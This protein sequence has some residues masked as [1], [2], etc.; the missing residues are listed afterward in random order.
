[1]LEN[2]SHQAVSPEWQ[3]KELIRALERTNKKKEV[4]KVR[5]HGFRLLCSSPPAVPIPK[6]R[7]KVAASCFTG[8]SYMLAPLMRT[9]L[10]PAVSDKTVT[11]MSMPLFMIYAP[12]L[13]D[14]DIGGAKL[15]SPYPFIFEQ[16][17]QGY[18]NLLT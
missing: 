7:R 6:C 5:Q 9:Y 14:R 1:M 17:P 10:N 15:P 11:T 3:Q 12:N 4:T 16:G 18:M 8:L 13:K 2:R